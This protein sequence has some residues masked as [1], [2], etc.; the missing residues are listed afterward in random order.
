MKR[1]ETIKVLTRILQKKESE[2]AALQESINVLSGAIKE[3][4]MADDDAV[5][6]PHRGTF[7]EELVSAIYD[8]LEEHGPLHR[9]V[10]L[11]K[12]LELGLHVGGGVRT[13]GSYLSADDR[14]KNVGKGLWVLEEPITDYGI[15]AKNGYH[16]EEIFPV[17]NS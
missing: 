1:I 17:F 15:T 10:I 12:I 8:V 4:E 2:L 16:Q 11:Q 6:T 14:F 5:T 3:V 7:K 9:N 13:V